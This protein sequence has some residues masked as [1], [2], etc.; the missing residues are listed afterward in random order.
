MSCLVAEWD[1]KWRSPT[2]WSQLRG[3]EIVGPN[4]H[5][6]REGFNHVARCLISPSLGSRPCT[7]A[8]ETCAR[9]LPLFQRIFLGLLPGLASLQWTET[10]PTV[11]PTQDRPSHPALVNGHTGCYCVYFP[12][13]N[14]GSWVARRYHRKPD[15]VWF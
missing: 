11:C 3:S 2:P 8:P 12:C 13:P 7:I 10:Q 15:G 14:A 4:E 5:L 6:W 1:E 9:L